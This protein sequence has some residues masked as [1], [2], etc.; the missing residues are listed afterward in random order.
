MPL[1]APAPLDEVEARARARKKMEKF[2]R[3]RLFSRKRI[4]RGRLSCKTVRRDHF[5]RFLQI[6]DGNLSSLVDGSLSEKEITV[7]ALLWQKAS[8]GFCHCFEK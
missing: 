2:K 8:L 5:Y 7:L 1:V 4:R 3:G 6:A